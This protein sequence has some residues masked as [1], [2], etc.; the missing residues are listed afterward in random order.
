MVKIK[1]ENA[2]TPLNFVYGNNHFEP[3]K[4]YSEITNI[5]IHNDDKKKEIMHNQNMNIKNKTKNS[6]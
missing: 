5:P 3:T 1:Q 2:S 6:D 4:I